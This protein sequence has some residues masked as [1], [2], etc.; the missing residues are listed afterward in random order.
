MQY[1]LAEKLL[2]KKVNGAL[3]VLDR[4]KM[5]V[6]DEGKMLPSPHLMQYKLEK[7]TLGRYG[8]ES[9]NSLDEGGL[10]QCPTHRIC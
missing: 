2:L 5:V 9:A 4:A 6:V 8:V 10:V 1:K 7:T 3:T